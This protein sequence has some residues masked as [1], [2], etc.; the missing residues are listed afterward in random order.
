MAIYHLSAQIIGRGDG[1]SAT[2]AAAYRLGTAIHDERTGRRFD[3]SRKRGVDGWRIIGP[4][5]MPTRFRDPTQLWN[6]VEAT[7]KRQDAQLCREINVALPRELTSLQNTALVADWCQH[8]ADAGMVACVA[9]HHLDSDN[10]HAHVMLTMREVKPEGFG[11][12]VRAWNDRGMLDQ[13]REIWAEVVN[14]HLAAHRVKARVDHRTLDAQGVERTPTQHQGPTA[15]A[16]EQRGA[17]PDRLRVI[18]PTPTTMDH[19]QA[20]KDQARERS[21]VPPG[22]LPDHVR[23]A[24]AAV[25]KARETLQAAEAEETRR[26]QAEQHADRERSEKRQVADA[27]R[28]A[29]LAA[30]QRAET[31]GQELQTRKEAIERW[32]RNHRWRVWWWRHGVHGAIPRAVRDADVI[33][34]QVKQRA[35]Q[36]AR[37]HQNMAALAG[38]SRHALT[39]ADNAHQHGQRM[40]LEASRRVEEATEQARQANAHWVDVMAPGYEQRQA[41]RRQAAARITDEPTPTRRRLRSP[42]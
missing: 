8:F 41:E 40:V 33:R 35:A 23:Q 11:P 26:R 42:R 28:K 32:K 6:A 17:V 3:Y 27:D 14:K 18:V 4:T 20:V 37:H 16:M 38:A 9:L 1:R 36:A 10:P 7:E 25:V 30:R 22:F 24:A 31:L 21:P 5:H 13:W 2:A 15:H 12:K 34:A 19:A 29:A 39:Q